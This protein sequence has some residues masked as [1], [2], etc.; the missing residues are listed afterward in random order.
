MSIELRFGM[1]FE[2]SI[3]SSR[4]GPDVLQLT[5]RDLAVELLR[6]RLIER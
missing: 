5:S 1:S 3:V 4:F 6:E 2:V